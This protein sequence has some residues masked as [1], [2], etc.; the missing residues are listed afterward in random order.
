MDNQEEKVLNEE[1]WKHEIKAVIS[2]VKDY[3]KEISIAE[4]I[5]CS[6]SEIYCNITTFE[7]EKFCIELTSSGFRYC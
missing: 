7:G 3:V 1:E 6:N 5:P 2:D 4:E